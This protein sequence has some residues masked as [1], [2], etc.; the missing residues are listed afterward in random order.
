MRKPQFTKVLRLVGVIYLSVVGAWLTAQTT[1]LDVTQSAPREKAAPREDADRAANLPAGINDS[2]LD[3]EMKVEDFI[4]RFEIESREVFACR[5]QILAAVQLEPG[6]A[7]A[8][9]GAGTGLYLGAFSKAVGKGGTVYAVDISP[10]FVKHLRERA[11]QEKLGNVEVVLC[12]DRDVNLRP[13]S[14]DRV[15]ICDVYHHFEYP[16][17]SLASIYT[18]MRA[19]GQLVLV[20]F[21]N[22]VEGERGE[23]LRNHVRASQDVFKQEVIDAGFKFVEEVTIDGF[24]EN[25]LL[26]FVK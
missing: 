9:I 17:S 6:M 10:N 22:D 15:F 1:T 7:V 13:N 16:S 18:A 4:K 5:K 19:G 26:R 3:P 14:V 20:D 11:K 21:H 23:W 8:D 12:S 2:F 24:Q 25:Y